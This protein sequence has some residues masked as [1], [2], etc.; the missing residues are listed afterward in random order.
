MIKGESVEAKATTALQVFKEYLMG[1]T[2]LSAEDIA[3][4]LEFTGQEI[5][6][7]MINLPEGMNLEPNP[8]G[9][10]NLVN[11][12]NVLSE[13]IPVSFDADGTVSA[14]TM[15]AFEEAGMLHAGHDVHNIV[16]YQETTITPEELVASKHEGLTKVARDLWYD[17]DTEAPIFDKNELGTWWGG[18]NNIG[19]DEDG[20]FVFNIAHITSEGSYHGGFSADAEELVKKGGVK[21]LLSMSRGTQDMVFEVPIDVNGNAVIDPDSEI[22][23]MFFSVEDGKAVFE[24]RFAEVAQMMGSEDGAE[25]VRILSTVEGNGIDGVNIIEEVGLRS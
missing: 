8:D 15:Q 12:G 11:N 5:D 19:I 3:E 24:G 21:M 17:N 14:E 23:K 9:T 6:G 16:E 10:F 7:H 20:N 22:G 25:H 13:N 18:E 4:N 2:G 1:Q